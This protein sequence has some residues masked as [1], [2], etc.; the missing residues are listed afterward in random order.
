VGQLAVVAPPRR[1]LD[2]IVTAW[3]TPPAELG[4]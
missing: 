3:Q 4:E 1:F 2:Q